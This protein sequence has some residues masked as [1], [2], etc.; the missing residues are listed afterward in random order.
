MDGVPDGVTDR[1][2]RRRFLRGGLLAAGAASTALVGCSDTS[3]RGSHSSTSSSSSSPSSP[4]TTL[5]L[6]AAAWSMLASSLTGHLVLPSSPSY[7]NA[8]L[9]YDPRF[10]DINPA[11][12]AY[13]AS[14]TDVQRCIAFARA[15]GVVPVP[16]CGGHSYGGYSSGPGLVIDVTSMNS[17]TVSRAA[18][19]DQAQ[20]VVGSGTLLIDFYNGLSQSG[21]LVPGGSCPTV[22]ISGLALG[23]GVGVVGRKYGLTCDTIESLQIVTADGRLLT[24]DASTDEDLYWACRGGGGGNFGVVTS[25][26]F[27]AS[28]IPPLAL[29]TL[30]WPSSAAAD[31]LGAWLT[32]QHGGPDELWT[33]CEVLS[34]GTGA[35]Q[36]RTAGMFVGSSTALGSL[37][38]TLVSAV[39]TQP[40]SRF[41][42]P[43]QYLHAMLVEA[44]CENVDVAQCHLS[45]QNPAGTLSRSAFVASSAYVSTIPGATGVDAFV[46]SV[47]DLTQ[48]LPGLGGGLAFDAY[49]GA[50]NAV[51]PSDTAFVHRNAVAGIQA[52]VSTGASAS[53]VTQG[54]SWLA[55]FAGET[56][57]YVDGSAYQNYIDPTLGDWAN[58]YYGANLDRL[59]SVKGKYDPDDAFHFAQSIPNHQSG[60]SSLTPRK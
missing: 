48:T 15:H 36:V 10:D 22:G 54:R 44:G 12:V 6:D 53:A 27:R 20:A 57:P 39:G 7:A 1:Y 37:V 40:T 46:Q 34:D 16:R 11:A 60:T 55:H 23:G 41:V 49:G 26:T 58:A 8:R 14:P 21:V 33:N 2:N 43:E 30:D 28:P 45:T 32:W 4:S 3:S 38:T 24:C 31:V 42:G 59:V 47:T 9:L 17:V 19:A 56:A 25:F 52:S 13:C 50:I 5:A 51:N 18:G 35:L 29:F